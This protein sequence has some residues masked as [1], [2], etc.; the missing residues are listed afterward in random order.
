MVSIKHVPRDKAF[1]E[2]RT[3]KKQLWRFFLAMAA[4]SLLFFFQEARAQITGPDAA[5]V[6]DA[7]LENA[8]RL[9]EDR[10]RSSV[11][12]FGHATGIATRVG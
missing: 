10:I 2:S 7:E 6:E 8:I 3:A 12:E 1:R 4:V 5:R 9:L 11:P